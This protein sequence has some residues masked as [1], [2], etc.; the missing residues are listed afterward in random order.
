[1]KLD[2]FVIYLA[3]GFFIAYGI[4]FMLAPVAMSGLVT[5]SAPEGVSA[6]VDF[7]A[8]YGGMTLAVGLAI[9]YLHRATHTRASLVLVAMLL[10]CMALG[11]VIGLIV[12][13]SGNVLM[14]VYL[15]LEIAGSALALLA[16]KNQSGPEAH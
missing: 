13:G 3:A 9:L 8:T 5:G 10:S 12:D 16:M 11:R 15:V 2:T 1:M 4:V 6:M 7:R 14:Y